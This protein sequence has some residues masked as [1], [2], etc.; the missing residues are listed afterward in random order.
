MNSKCSRIYLFWSR[1][2]HDWLSHTFWSREDGIGLE[3]V[4]LLVQFHLVFL[5]RLNFSVKLFLLIIISLVSIGYDDKNS[6]TLAIG[7]SHSPAASPTVAVNSEATKRSGSNS[8]IPVAPPSSHSPESKSF[9]Y[10]LTLLLVSFYAIVWLCFLFVR[11]FSTR[12]NI[13]YQYSWK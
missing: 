1:K 4:Q 5:L 12:V 6:N 3:G 9:T 10:A 13:Y 2:L 8:S 7:P 11:A